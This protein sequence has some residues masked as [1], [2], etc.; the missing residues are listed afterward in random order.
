MATRTRKMRP[1]EQGRYRP[2]IGWYWDDGKGRRQPRFF[3]GTDL[4]EAERRR[5][6]IEELYDENCKVNGEDCWSP[7]AL[8]YAQELAKGKKV[9]EYPP[10]PEGDGYENPMREYAQMIEVDQQRFPSLQ[11]IPSDTKLYTESV[12]LNKDLLT[13]RMRQLEAELKEL[14]ALVGQKEFPDKLIV[15]TF[16]EALDAYI[17]MIQRDGSK[18]E[19][20]VLK[21]YQR[22][23][24]IR[25]KRFKRDHADF[26]LYALN[27]DKCSE[28]VGFWRNRPMTLRKTRSSKDNSRHHITE[29]FTFFDWLDATEKFGWSAPRA[30]RTI[31]RKVAEFNSERQLTAITKETYTPEELAVLNRHANPLERLALYLG[32]NCAMGAAELGRLQLDNFTFR[33]A[34]P[35]MDVLHFSSTDQDTF[36]AT[37]RPKTGVY[38]EWLLWPETVELV[39][40]GFARA[41]QIGSQL[42][43][44][45]E[46]AQPMYNEDSQ[47]PQ[48]EFENSWNRLLERTQKS[49]PDF[50]CLP[51]G[52]L[53]DTAPDLLRTKYKESEL[54]SIMLAHGSPNRNDSLLDCY[55]KK[56]FGHLHDALRTK[57][58]AD[59]QPIFQAAPHCP[60]SEGKTYLPIVTL[61]KVRALLVEGKGATEIARACGVS[62]TT[63]YRVKAKLDEEQA[64]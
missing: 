12:N 40:W 64:G 14:G 44:V 39:E 2:R 9:I 49:F 59:Y 46:T 50:R 35:Y 36:L 1:D 17:E 5:S 52:T 21:P 41:E 10:L 54:A 22:L 38:G 62:T 53:R 16:H 20:G 27:H 30:L 33:K 32:L 13:D 34:H 61:D 56:P 63:V 31:D 55:A 28:L 29:L 23:R 7:L 57:L 42:L 37:L 6:K 8:S 4:K 58:Y 11:I 24:I 25:A 60:T 3:L 26:P 15:G 45:R 48:S 18:L 51:F 43:F 47:N 19:S